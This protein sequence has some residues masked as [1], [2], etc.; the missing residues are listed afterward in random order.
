[1]SSPT[2]LEALGSQAL[3]IVPSYF[4]KVAVDY[5]EVFTLAK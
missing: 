5:T 3:I 2:D 4:S 1:M